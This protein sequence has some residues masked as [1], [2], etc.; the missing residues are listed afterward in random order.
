MNS[1]L[2]TDAMK[3]KQQFNQVIELL[4]VLFPEQK[5]VVKPLRE[6]LDSNNFSNQDITQQLRSIRQALLQ[7]KD[8]DAVSMRVVTQSIK[9]QLEKIARSPHLSGPSKARLNA[10]SVEE[11]TSPAE[12][13]RALTDACVSF[14]N[15]VTHLRQQSETIVG[16]AHNH[17]KKDD[18]KII[19]GDVAW[20]SRQIL[21]SLLPL[22]QRAAINHPD[23]TDIKN[24][25]DKTRSALKLS[26]VDFYDALAL[27]EEAT[28]LL[29]KLQSKKNQAEAV[30][31]KTFH[32]HLKNM[33][34][35]LLE[36]IKTS[37]AFQ[38]S[39]EQ[40]QE[41]MIDNLNKFKE[42]SEKQD[43][44]ELLRK[45]IADN[46]DA[47]KQGMDSMMQ[48]QNAFIR[49]QQRSMASMQSEIR[50]QKRQHEKLAQDHKTLRDVYAEAE[51]MAL[52]DVLTRCGNRRAFDLAIEK[53][54]QWV[55]ANDAFGACGLIVMDVDRF[56]S[57]NDEHGHAGGDEVLKSI[58]NI[59]RDII[60]KPGLKG[61]A[62]VYRYGGEEF[63]IICHKMK[64]QDMYNLAEIL[65]YNIS[66]HGFLIEGKKLE[67]T[68]SLGVAR[69][70]KLDKSGQA[71][72]K[73]ADET[74]YKAK[75]AGRN[76]V[77]VYEDGQF[78]RVKTRE[79]RE[80]QQ[81]DNSGS[82]AAA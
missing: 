10:I 63:V 61:R 34:Q 4:E 12:S 48:K 62:R 21:N 72:F 50:E 41:K 68:A 27:M 60:A 55:Q 26:V 35:A 78:K 16:E 77:F 13:L 54:D 20:S 2:T 76:R 51:G 47:M 19:A 49:Q 46:V 8:Q 17:L 11:C 25:L 59:L 6:K 31:L 71:V 82:G 43:D 22:L 53:I 81:S 42:A 38:S 28:K 39:S 80:Q 14:A 18:A 15:E 5:S 1:E 24:T 30:Y 70:S 33:H 32:G 66:K 73:M 67:C 74:L 57:I 58:G 37:A 45:L 29:T 3:N 52:R 79:E 56:K 7:A 23:N 64:K 36:T 40:D 69:Y 9:S 65:R 75:Q 44:P